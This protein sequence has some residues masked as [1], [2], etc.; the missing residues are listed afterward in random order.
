MRRSEAYDI[1]FRLKK[2]RKIDISQQLEILATSETVPNEIVQFIDSNSGRTL[3]DF[4]NV[5]SKQKHFYANICFNYRNDISTYVKA[6]LSLLTHIRITI[7]KNPELR[8]KLNEL[9]DIETIS[10]VVTRNLIYND[11]DN[12]VIDCAKRIKLVYLTNENS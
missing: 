6:F 5:I 10:S 8:E 4:I 9:F 11:N 7:D 2:E 1:L 12:D 3:E